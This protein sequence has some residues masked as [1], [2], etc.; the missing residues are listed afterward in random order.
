MNNLYAIA[1]L[2]L[3][4]GVDKKMDVFYGWENY[5]D[6]IKANWQRMVDDG[7]TVVIAGDISWG[8]NL[9]ESQ[10]DFAFLHSLPGKK[11]IL[12]GNH[13]FWWSTLSK[14]NNFLNE[15][16]YSDFFVL[17]NNFYKIGDYAVCG[18]RGWQYDAK[19]TDINIV[20]RECARIETS[21]KSAMAEG[22][23]PIVFLH[24]PP[25]YGEYK[26]TE[27]IETLKSNGITEVY[28]GH[29]HGSGFNKALKF[30]DDIKL[31]IISCD[32]IDFTPKFICNY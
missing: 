14:I 26:S 31:N 1:D 25:A 5:T 21:I 12:K 7:D 22:L 3:S 8:M 30:A 18:S 4:F 19:Q 15:N 32:C 24:Y 9:E 17:H 11:V 28:Y 10:K 2:H 16:D 6:K 13:D 29:I 27:I 23:K 20:N